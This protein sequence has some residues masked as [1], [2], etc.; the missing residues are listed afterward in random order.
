MQSHGL[1]VSRYVTAGMQMEV[2]I[3]VVVEYLLHSVLQLE[4]LLKN[5]EMIQMVEVMGAKCHGG[6]LSLGIPHSG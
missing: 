4:C 1:K 3:N 2:E 5:T 6:C